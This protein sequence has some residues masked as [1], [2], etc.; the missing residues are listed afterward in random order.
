MNINFTEKERIESIHVGK[1]RVE[2]GKMRK[3]EGE[4]EES[5][6]RK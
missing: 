5:E 2:A 3:V 6:V 1:R 4:N